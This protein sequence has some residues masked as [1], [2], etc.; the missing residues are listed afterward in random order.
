MTQPWD[1]QKVE[2]EQFDHLVN[3]AQQP[4]WWH[5]VV[6]RVRQLEREGQDT[7]PPMFAGLEQRVARQLQ[8]LGFKPPRQK[9][10]QAG[11]QARS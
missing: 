1:L 3:L 10:P 8:Q 4:G 11:G 6:H 7:S 9:S 5:Y 2:Q